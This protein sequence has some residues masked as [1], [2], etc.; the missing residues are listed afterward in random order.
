MKRN[1]SDPALLDALTEIA[2][3]AG[4]AIM[5]VRRAGAAIRSKADASPVTEADEAAEAIILE[6]LARTLPDVAVVSEE[7]AQ[8]GLPSALPDIFILVDPLDGTREFIDGRDEFTVNIAI[9]RSGR[10]IAG[11]VGAPALDAIWRGAEGAGA[12]RLVLQPGRAPDAASERVALRT[13]PHR[14]G[15]WRAMVSRSHLDPK[16]EEW[17]TR[18]AAVE[19]MDC[20]SSVKFC[21]IAEGK[22]DVYP[23]LGRTSEWDIAAGDAVLSAAGG[24]VLSL[25]GTP[26]RYGQVGRDLKVPSFVAWCD[27]KDAAAY[28]AA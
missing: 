10:P 23:R 13:H 19:R 14:G 4:E 26:L 11:V 6:G 18:F 16:T 22:A 2:S 25:D 21:R 15:P 7:A 1:Y 20:G 28:S 12:E 17:L 3:R 5:R 9:L 8:L 24:V 27:P